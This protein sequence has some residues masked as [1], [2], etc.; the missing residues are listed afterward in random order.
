MLKCN[1]LFIIKIGKDMPMSNDEFLSSLRQYYHRLRLRISL[2]ILILLTALVFVFVQRIVS[3]LL[4]GGGIVYYLIFIRRAQNRY[5]RA[6]THANLACTIAPAIF[7]SSIEEDGGSS[8]TKETI[9]GAG[10]MPVKNV[11]GSPLLRWGMDGTLNGFSLSLCD[12]TIAQDFSLAKRGKKRVHFNSGV[13]V[14]IALPTNTGQHWCLLD[15]TSVP[16]PIRME[17]FSHRHRMQTTP[18]GND[19]LG[20]NYVLYQQA[21]KSQPLSPAVL[22]EVQKLA[23]YTPGYPAFS[24]KEMC[25]DVFIRGRFLAGPVSMA[26]APT[27]ELLSFD[28]FPELDY[29][30]KIAKAVCFK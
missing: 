29:I 23:D 30:L 6:F 12:A 4:L 19:V 13:W 21:E 14:H 15:E 10:L 16:T 28:P 18:I 25:L 27:Q 22:R 7:A 8:I 17:Y 26:K 3:L 20:K 24:V 1:Q 2:M 9:T 11:S 5:T